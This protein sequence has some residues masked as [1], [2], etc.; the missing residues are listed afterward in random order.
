MSERRIFLKQL[1]LNTAGLVFLPAFPLLSPAP[2]RGPIVP[3]AG[4]LAANGPIA[5]AAARPFAPGPLPRSTPE[6]QGISSASIRAF[7]AAIAASGQEF[8]SIMVIRHG[9]VV[10]EG[11]WS[12]FSAQQH[13]QL[14]SLSKSFTGTAIGM[15][16]GERRLSIEDPV[17]SFFPN[18]RPATISNNLA[19]LKVK[20]LLSMSVG[21]DKD[22]IQIIEKSPAGDTWEKTF[23][24][25]P[26]VFEPGTHFLYNSGASYM[27]SSI[28]SKVTGKS[29]HEYLKPRL[30]EPLGITGATWTE[31]AE[32]V[33]MG[34]SN[35]RIRTEDIGKLGQL[36][37]QQGNWKDQQLVSR[38]WV[39]LATKKEIET[40]GR[41]DSSWGFGYGYQFWMNPTGGFR[42]DGAYGQYS[43][44]FPDKDTVV[45]VTSESADKE[46]TMHT[47]WDHLYP[48]LTDNATLPPNAAEHDQL[49]KELKTLA[50]E[51]PQFGT[52]S[53]MEA[54]LSEKKYMLD[55]N[56]F[57]AKAVSFRFTGDKTIFTVMEDG[58][59][60]IVIACGT[61]KWIMEGNRKPSAHSLFSLRR[62]DFDSPVAASAGWK[63]DHTLV[64]TFRFVEAIHGD[65]LTCM[66]DEDRLRVQFLFSGARMDKRADERPDLTGKS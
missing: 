53:P 24:G 30:Y 9:H 29:V 34:A 57:N 14:Y 5:P 44:V 42:A 6:Q 51:P 15:A 43:M 27:L 49:Q 22:S 8:H 36:Y 64:L 52:R 32:G 23:L 26:V 2:P 1:G 56:E 7:L 20:H 35:L 66:F 47:V 16:A 55:K 21:Q 3:A 33:N 39:A 19:K 31:N 45:V 65:T 62:I 12:P 40:T 38:E 58:K 61:N 4:S 63:D 48:A 37:L 10:A 46:S 17:I 54:A 28:I 50:L 11:W 25:L 13:Q 18:D 41:N 59:P 60:D